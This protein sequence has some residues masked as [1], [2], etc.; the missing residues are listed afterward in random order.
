[1]KSVRRDVAFSEWGGIGAAPKHVS[2]AC[3]QRGMRRWER[4][5]VKPAR[6]SPREASHQNRHRPEKTGRVNASESLVEAPLLQPAEQVANYGGNGPRRAVFHLLR[7]VAEGERS[8]Q[9]LSFSSSGGHTCRTTWIP[10]SLGRPTRHHRPLRVPR[11]M[12]TAFVLN[13]N[14]SISRPD[15]PQGFH[16]EGCNTIKIDLD[17]DAEEDL[18]YRL[19]F[20][21]RDAGGGSPVAASRQLLQ[22]S[23][24]ALVQWTD[25]THGPCSPPG[26]GSIRAQPSLDKNFCHFT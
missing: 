5:G 9:P 14:N 20:G 8:H 15:A 2:K 16:P 22:S 17:G 24:F 23:S 4:R 18:A 12:G 1:M 26:A 21:E 13:V 25:A 7:C 3:P 19:A 10:R 6:Q 11:E